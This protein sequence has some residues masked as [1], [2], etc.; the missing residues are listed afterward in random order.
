MKN[1]GGF[2]RHDCR[3]YAF[4]ITFLQWALNNTYSQNLLIMKSYLRTWYIPVLYYTVSWKPNKSE[5]K[6]K[7]NLT[8]H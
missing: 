4:F 5:C 7:K 1:K 2:A 3:F 8:F 6:L